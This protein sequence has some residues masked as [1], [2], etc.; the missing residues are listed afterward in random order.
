MTLTT[1]IRFLKQIDPQA[2]EQ[3]AQRLID[4][5]GA[6]GVTLT[7]TR[8]VDTLDEHPAPPSAFVEL[9]VEIP[10]DDDLGLADDL[11]FAIV[12]AMGSWAAPIAWQEQASRQ[13]FSDPREAATPY[14]VLIELRRQAR[15]WEHLGVADEFSRRL[16]ADSCRQIQLMRLD[17]PAQR[18]RH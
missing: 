15:T 8:V 16:L 2:V 14:Y 12:K 18:Q 3:A 9:R 11:E 4:A 17:G 10:D 7:A 1:R 13:W 6:V 5:A